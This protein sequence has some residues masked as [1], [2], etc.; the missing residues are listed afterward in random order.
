MFMR[1]T[2]VRHDVNA[3][4]KS[5]RRCGKNRAEL[6]IRILCLVFLLILT[7]ICMTA[8]VPVQATEEAGAEI[9]S[10]ENPAGEG[11]ITGGNGDLSGKEMIRIVLRPVKTEGEPDPD[12]TE[13]IRRQIKE[14]LRERIGQSMEEEETDEER[15]LLERLVSCVTWEYQ[16]DASVQPPGLER[17]CGESDIRLQFEEDPAYCFNK[18]ELPVT[19]EPEAGI[20][21]EPESEVDPTEADPLSEGE[22][23]ELEYTE[24]END[25]PPAEE[26]QPE[27]EELP[28]EEILQ[29]T[30]EP[31]MEEPQ[32]E[33]ED[34]PVEEP[35]PETEGPPTEE[36]QPEME[37]PPAE[38]PQPETEEPPAEEILP[39]TEEPG[40][41]DEE[42]ALR[43]YLTTVPREEN[44]E[45]N[46]ET[47]QETGEGHEAENDIP[48]ADE[49]IPE[50]PEEMV[51]PDPQD[52]GAAG[53]VE[54]EYEERPAGKEEQ[55]EEY[56]DD[57]KTEEITEPQPVAEASV[58]EPPGTEPGRYYVHQSAG[59]TP[60]SYPLS[61][62]DTVRE[63]VKENALLNNDESRAK[64]QIRLIRTEKDNSETDLTNM[65]S[66]ALMG[67]K[68][69]RVNWRTILSPLPENDGL[70]TLQVTDIDENGEKTMRETSFS[71]NRFGS[72]YTYN[73]I[74]RK[75]RGNTVRKITEPLVI[76]EYNPDPLQ[77]GSWEID[78]THDGKKVDPAQ[79]TVS[80][81]K[82][83]QQE[84]Q[85]GQ[86]E[87]TE[88]WQRYD[89]VISPENFREDG[90]YRL[91]VS[92]ADASGN[93]PESNRYN[94]GEIRF[95][96]DGSPPEL[97]TVSGLETPVVYGETAK[98][99]V[100]AFDAIGLEK[101]AIFADG[102]CKAAASDFSDSHRA[103]VT[104][105]LS[106]GEDQTVR[107]VVTDGASNTLDTEAKDR[108]GKYLFRPAY[109]FERKISVLRQQQELQQ[110]SQQK[111]QNLQ[112]Q[113]VK[114]QT[115]KA[116]KRKHT[117]MAL[118][119][120]IL[121]CSGAAFWLL[122]RARKK[123]LAQA[124]IHRID[125]EEEDIL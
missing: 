103:E 107:I 50:Q 58:P 78:L 99:T 68:P 81:A 69:E 62:V 47:P 26:P 70:Y 108:T 115:E 74:I 110:E 41:P 5:S 32:P 121:G 109:P 36:P 111:Q 3:G 48:E 43:S 120:M 7:K 9:L 11:P 15:L 102:K 124:A 30:E 92:S 40:Y 54:Q 79:Y 123:D 35:Q 82:E 60:L 67:M 122:Y 27:T 33:T 87:K 117:G 17:P 114:Q 75:L 24:A 83:E 71:V 19:P 85:E 61:P 38:E 64:T 49:P 23:S 86:P 88:K 34:S 1:K 53:P 104:A 65:Y 77:S 37:E 100:T 16:Y 4:G 91:I 51:V 18:P 106:P 63:A 59:I 14:Q 57:G 96:V 90:A 125:E 93:T 28:A 94:G 29:E 76:S 97:Q 66:H 119:G 73:D 98:I 42:E 84:N 112:K 22:E 113:Q 39:E 13:E 21:S 25:E 55:A 6:T 31:P 56:H 116:K 101:V 44:P 12:L 105:E 80:P 89:Y 10:T 52:E 20:G 118:A 8:E 45:E 46:T 2:T 72:V 95:T